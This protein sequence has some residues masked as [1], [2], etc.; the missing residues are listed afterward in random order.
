MS[1]KNSCWR[2]IWP[3]QYDSIANRRIMFGFCWGVLMRVRMRKARVACGGAFAAVVLGVSTAA[4][5]WAAS[6]AL[7]IGGIGTPTMH[8]LVM[9]QLLGGALSDVERVSVDWPAEAR[10]YTGA[11]DLTLGASIDVGITNLNAEIDAALARLS[12]DENGNVINGERVTVVG[13]SAGSLV[14]TEVLRQLVEDPDAPDSRD[15]N[16]VVVADSSRQEIIDDT[17]RY[18]PVYDY[19]YRPAPET[20][21]DTIVVTAEYD[22]FADFP[23]RWWNVLAVANAMAGSIFVHIPAMFADLTE[24]PAENITVDVNSKGGS[25]THYLVPAERL[26]LVQLIPSL[27]PQEAALKESI[28]KGYS[29][30]DPAPSWLRSMFTDVPEAVEET[31]AP[32]ADETE[33]APAVEAAAR[34][35]DAVAPVEPTV[36]EA[37]SADGTSTSSDAGRPVQGGNGDDA[38][39]SD[40]DATSLKDEDDDGEAADSDNADEASDSDRAGEASGDEGTP[41][42]EKGDR[43]VKFDRAASDAQDTKTDRVTK[44]DRDSDSTDK[45]PSRDPGSSGSTDSAD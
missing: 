2:I 26:P 7:V 11:E 24:V 9:S 13:L 14:V 33:R 32:V 45:S 34:D 18:N 16:F 41:G 10:P 36:D 27:A 1:Q 40:A 19:T 31:V 17:E 39:E 12:R 5:G 35:R 6:T 44:R 15:I 37:D 38:A 21:Y 8:D 30:N 25:T 22:G 28:D 4:S 42:G 43:S 23:D 3:A 20:E 29:R